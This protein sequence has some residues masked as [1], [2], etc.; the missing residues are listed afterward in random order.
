[1]AV[2][3]LEGSN[4]VE[5]DKAMAKG[6]FF[7]IRAYGLLPVPDDT[8]LRVRYL[9]LRQLRKDAAEYGQERRANT[10]KNVAIAMD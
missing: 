8:E 9:R 3:A 10:H 6:A 7:A 2:E 5:I 1:M 4:R